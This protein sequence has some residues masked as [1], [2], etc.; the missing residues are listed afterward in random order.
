MAPVIPSELNQVNQSCQGRKSAGFLQ[1]T[2]KNSIIKEIMLHATN[3]TLP[4]CIRLAPI[5][6][7]ST[8]TRFRDYARRKHGHFQREGVGGYRR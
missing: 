3:H 2:G 1:E 8:G 6:K 7:P 4:H 5:N